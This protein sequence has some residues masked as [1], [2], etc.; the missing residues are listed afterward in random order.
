MAKTC[1]PSAGGQGSIPDQGT[2]SCMPQ[3]RPGI[4]KQI[5]FKDDGPH[6]P[7][8]PAP[9]SPFSLLSCPIPILSLTPVSLRMVIESPRD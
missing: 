3:L 1:I 4:A 9:D 7:P 8:P 2:R 5:Q 6:L